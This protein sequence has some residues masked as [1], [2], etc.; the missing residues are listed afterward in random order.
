MFALNLCVFIHI[1]FKCLGRVSSGL[2]NSV[3]VYFSS[4]HG[5][6]WIVTCYISFR[7]RSEG[8]LTPFHR[9]NV[10]SEAWVFSLLDISLSSVIK[11]R[12]CRTNYVCWGDHMNIAQPS[13]NSTLSAI[14]ANLRSRD[15]YT[16]LHKFQVHIIWGA[17]LDGFL[18]VFIFNQLGEVE[19]I[20]ISSFTGSSSHKCEASQA[21][22]RSRFKWV[23]LCLYLYWNCTSS[24]LTNW[25]MDLFYHFYLMH[26]IYHLDS[27]YQC[28]QSIYS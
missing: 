9:S 25:D 1:K 16:Q 12:F 7:S 15:M 4:M 18:L 27:T 22:L 28:T 5:V 21:Q 11:Q 17:G 14:C 3:S 26:S 24:G 23:C 20:C 19:M 8:Q 13:I 10:Y 6:S 2:S